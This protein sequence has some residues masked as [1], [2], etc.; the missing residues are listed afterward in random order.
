M[1]Y[2]A[3]RHAHFDILDHTDSPCSGVVAITPRTPGNST[4]TNE[5]TSVMHREKSAKQ[6]LDRAH[7]LMGGFYNDIINSMP[8][9]DQR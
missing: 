1:P 6:A 9:Q 4:Y 8:K 7:L 2:G 3:M 5:I